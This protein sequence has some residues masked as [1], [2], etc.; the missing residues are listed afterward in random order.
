MERTKAKN[1]GI[2]LIALAVTIVVT[3]I[4][5]SITLGTLLGDNGIIKNSQ[6]SKETAEQQSERNAVEQAATTAMTQNRYGKLEESIFKEELNNTTE[7]TETNT[8][9]DIFSVI[10]TFE[11]TERTYEV[12]TE[13]GEVTPIPY[14][15][16]N[17]GISLSY[18]LERDGRTWKQDGS[19]W[20][21]DNVVVTVNFDENNSEYNDWTENKKIMYRLEKDT[22]WKEYNDSS[23]IVSERNQKVYVKVQG[24]ENRTK[25]VEG[26]V[27]YI[28]KIKPVIKKVEVAGN[29]VKIEATDEA[30]GIIGY[31]VTTS[32]N[33]PTNFTSCTNTKEFN[34]VVTAST[35][36]KNYYVWVKDAAG[37]I[38]SNIYTVIAEEIPSGDEIIITHTPTEWTNGDVTATASS[39]IADLEIQMS[40]DNSN[41]KTTKTL[42][43]EQ[44]G[45]VYARFWNGNEAGSATTH[46]I[47]NIDKIKPTITVNPETS[48]ASKTKEI[49]ITARDEGGSGLSSSNSYHY[50][51]ST[52]KTSQEGGEWKGYTSGQAFPIGTGLNGTYYLHI[53]PIKDNATNISTTASTQ[54]YGPYVFANKAPTITISPNNQ[55]NY[56]KST[57]V[58]IT[59]T[60]NNGVG[61][62]SSNSYQ[63]YLS[64]SSTSQVGGSWQ[65]YTSGQAFPIGEG[66]TG[67]YYIHVKSV[68]DNAGNS[69]GNKVSGAF[70]FDNTAPVIT[71]TPS[72]PQEPVKNATITI[73]ASDT[74]GSKLNNN[75]S[76]Q[77]YLST[78]S[79]SFSGGSWTPYNSGQSFTIGTGL[80]GT[81]YLFVKQISD[82]A[83]NKSKQNGTIITIGGTE[84]HRFGAYIFNNTKPKITISGT[85][86]EKIATEI[87][88]VGNGST[89]GE[90]M[91]KII[92]YY[93][94][95][96]ETT[97]S[98]V[99][100]IL[101]TPSQT[102][103]DNK[104]L[105]NLT[106]STTYDIYAE[107][108]DYA[109]ETATSEKIQVTTGP[110]VALYVETGI[111]YTKVQY[112]IDAVPNKGNVKLLMD[113][114]ECVTIATAKDITF[115]PNN[116][117]L[118]NNENS[119]VITNNGNLTIK[120]T[121]TISCI[122][123]TYA[124]RN[125]SAGTLNISNGTY[126]NANETWTIFNL[127]KFNFSG[128]NINYTSND[129]GAAVM[130]TG[131]I[132]MTGG[133]INSGAYGLVSRNST[134][135]ANITSGNII[136]TGDKSAL[137]AD[138]GGEG[139]KIIAR[140][141]TIKNTNS[142]NLA[143]QLATDYNSSKRGNY[144]HLIDCSITGRI[145]CQGK[146]STG[147]LLEITTSSTGYTIYYYNNEDTSQTVYFP[148]WTLNGG[149]ND[150]LWYKASKIRRYNCNAYY[151]TIN[152]SEHN[153]E[154]GTY[155]THVYEEDTNGTREMRDEIRIDV[156]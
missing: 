115:D 130:N 39:Q 33:Q 133:N 7:G 149:Q 143:V 131:T 62:S 92:W 107:V 47:S 95:T 38:G 102:A 124:I 91:E 77:Y 83:T 139:G 120:T 75:N 32:K 137:S 48:N 71:K 58:T 81:Y 55:S 98:K 128:G 72:N 156:N 3:I 35:T 145:I 141:T 97:Y 84:Y 27:K 29:Q 56:T 99:E 26:E 112:A 65:N 109:D 17:V 28:D 60:D 151:Y 117:T 123:G 46:Q 73:T 134:G 93:K 53:K 105:N 10:V 45:T 142:N 74:G 146:S 110:G 66:K 87:N 119:V 136:V 106:P 103:T 78:S 2:T 111:I 148:T 79:T 61:L 36:G 144:I 24:D 22:E 8:Y 94:K 67:T 122:N 37:N 86:S 140:N 121:G 51:L 147:S 4:I 57:N 30:S 104:L 43:V 1:S 70:Y 129:T 150:I 40:T 11:D 88:V 59:V 31:A 155:I 82:M 116:K 68:S 89:D 64:T 41:W 15:Y 6:S 25:V 44:N 34:K 154:S 153:N 118:S 114:K 14:P 85:A 80:N 12:D 52:S 132:T 49:T 18:S 42:T 5:A 13:T 138:G 16:E 113:W 127:G 50:Y 76:Y 101:N 125:G 19:E 20:T 100:T 108:Y 54:V 21:N 152:K 63:Y 96:S 135:N 126:T 23:K 90:G 9:D 69:S